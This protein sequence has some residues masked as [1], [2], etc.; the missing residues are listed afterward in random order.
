MGKRKIEISKIKN[1][2]TSQ[3]TY[4]KRK[5]GLIKKAMELALLCDVDFFLAI[6]DQKDRLSITCSKTPIQEFIRKNI[7]NMNNRIVKES[8]TLKDYQK[9]FCSEKEKKK[10][11]DNDNIEEEIRKL[12]EK[13]KETPNDIYLKYMNKYTNSD[14]NLYFVPKFSS[15][16]DSNINFSKFNKNENNYEKERNNNIK[17]HLT[18]TKNNEISIIKNQNYQNLNTLSKSEEVKSPSTSHQSQNNYYNQIN[19]F[20]PNLTQNNL[21]NYKNPIYDTNNISNM[22]NMF[23]KNQ[24]NDFKQNKNFYINPMIN[25]LNIFNEQIDELY[26]ILQPNIVYNDYSQNL[27]DNLKNGFQIY[28]NEKT[29]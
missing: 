15:K 28:E 23:E 24:K 8:F 25:N 7:I 1:K 14:K 9:I 11:M 18:I 6:V 20:F 26:H 16:Y 21:T 4:Y 22:I 2:L 19:H 13:I 12:N 29:E 5:K 3:I 10:Y 17:N 27:I